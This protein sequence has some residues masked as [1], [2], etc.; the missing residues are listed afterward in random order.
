M[1]YILILKLE[2]K[3]LSFF[4]NGT[5]HPEGERHHVPF[6]MLVVGT[7][8]LSASHCSLHFHYRPWLY[9]LDI[10][11]LY[12][13]HIFNNLHLISGRTQPYQC[14]SSSSLSLGTKATMYSSPHPASFEDLHPYLRKHVLVGSSSPC[15]QKIRLLNIAS[16][17]K[18]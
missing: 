6:N 11:I 18:R 13:F 14:P 12:L 15:P 5:R 9:I 16:F 1:K 7:V 8:C 2:I 17:S 3:Y 10:Y 4:R